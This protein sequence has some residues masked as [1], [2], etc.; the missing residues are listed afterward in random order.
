MK[1]KSGDV[2]ILHMCT[3]KQS[4]DVYVLRYEVQ[5]TTGPFFALLPHYW[6]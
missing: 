5:P 4:Y 3:K 2:I 6:P 1:Q